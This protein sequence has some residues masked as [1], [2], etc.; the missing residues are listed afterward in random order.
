MRT[1]GPRRA[2]QPRGCNPVITSFTL[3]ALSSLYALSKAQTIC[4][5]ILFLIPDFLN[6]LILDA[7]SNWFF[8]SNY[9][10]KKAYS[11]PTSSIVYFLVL[12][13]QLNFLPKF[14]AFLLYSHF[15]KTAFNSKWRWMDIS[16]AILSEWCRL[17]KCFLT[18]AITCYSQILQQCWI[19][20]EQF[21]KNTTKNT[22]DFFI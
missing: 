8:F 4:W 19:R 12:Q 15:P 13:Y 16:L 11:T 18:K 2:I 14:Q 17:M 7:S 22:W 21:C 3:L 9:L 10:W 20:D 6:F 5:Q 1:L